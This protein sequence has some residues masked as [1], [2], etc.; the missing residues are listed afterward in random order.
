MFGSAGCGGG[1]VG[2]KGCVRKGRSSSRCLNFFLRR[3]AG[4]ALSANITVD[5]IWAPTWANPADAPTRNYDIHEWNR[6][7]KPLYAANLHHLYQNVETRD[8]IALID[9]LRTAALPPS[10]V[11]ILSRC[12]VR[13]ATVM[14]G[15]SF[16][17]H[18]AGGI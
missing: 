2:A 11:R 14:G 10:A 16:Y 5:V 7:V 1:F 15:A 12:R 8:S 17:L 18:L 4:W 9:S 3:L 6:K 13:A